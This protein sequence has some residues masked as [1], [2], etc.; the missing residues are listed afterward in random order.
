MHV[1]CS[2]PAGTQKC[3]IAAAYLHLVILG[4]INMQRALTIIHHPL[5]PYYKGGNGGTD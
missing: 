3:L 5:L 4:V 1:L 2:D